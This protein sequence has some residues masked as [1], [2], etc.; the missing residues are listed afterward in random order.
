VTHAVSSQVRLSLMNDLDLGMTPAAEQAAKPVA[1]LV[2][3]IP[4]GELGKRVADKLAEFLAEGDWSSQVPVYIH[5]RTNGEDANAVSLSASI[6]QD[7]LRRE[8]IAE[9]E[10]HSQLRGPEAPLELFIVMPFDPSDAGSVAEASRLLAQT[11]AESMRIPVRYVAVPI[12]DGFLD[13]M[14]SL[15]SIG[16]DGWTMSIPFP[17]R[18]RFEGHSEESI[19]VARAA[20]AL[21]LLCTTGA[22]LLRLGRSRPGS[23][24]KLAVGAAWAAGDDGL[25]D[26][27]ADFATRKL[28]VDLYAPPAATAAPLGDPPT[29][30]RRLMNLETLVQRLVAK[31]PYRLE[32]DRIPWEVS[33]PSATTAVDVQGV[34]VDD[35][36]RFLRRLKRYY[37]FAR[38][39]RWRESL[40]AARDDVSIEI[41][42]AAEQDRS[43]C[44]RR[45]TGPK[46]ALVWAAA[47]ERVLDSPLDVARSAAE[48]FDSALTELENRI[49]ERPEPLAFAA[50]TA[51]LG[52]FGAGAAAN[53]ANTLYGPPIALAAAAAIVVATLVATICTLRRANAAIDASLWKAVRALSGS[54]E[55]LMRRNL[56]KVVPTLQAEAEK[57]VASAKTEARRVAASAKGMDPS[58]VNRD[59]GRSGPQPLEP[60]VP[61]GWEDLFLEEVAVNWSSLSREAAEA[62]VLVPTAT[63][64]ADKAEVP[65]TAALGFVKAWLAHNTTARSPAAQLAFRRRR[66]P[67]HPRKFLER[68]G[69]AASLPGPSQ[70]LCTVWAAPVELQSILP[71]SDEADPGE[72]R[73]VSASRIEC[74]KVG[75]LN[76]DPSPGGK[77]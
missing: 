36:P 58:R 39:R 53:F 5:R 27:L 70:L 67:G 51:L 26:R 45:P 14:S 57:L 44:Y 30:L 18:D 73:I 9:I 25:I 28:L 32:A 64:R 47:V 11:T 52:V 17:M 3:V 37:D 15:P 50:R 21:A 41:D 16:G 35:W 49:A 63:A 77:R 2:A 1:N 74:V 65:F 43:D 31:T 56:L 20:R 4:A 59:V 42:A 40:E 29:E 76:E 61:A 24:T 55:A 68:I 12:A 10:Q 72:V 62:G 23:T 6:R 71:G 33:L 19:T 22:S 38:A 60:L 69:C 48:D 8:R 7:L 46:A 34:A 54:Y 75:T 13:E 66:E